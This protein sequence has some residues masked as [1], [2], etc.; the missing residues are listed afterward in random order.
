MPSLRNVLSTPDITA[1]NLLKILWTTFVTRQFY[2]T[3]KNNYKI[4]NFLPAEQGQL[5]QAGLVFS[6]REVILEALQKQTGVKCRLQCIS[7]Y[8]HYQVLTIVIQENH[9]KILNSG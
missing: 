9:S 2:L 6:Y 7:C 3:K 1:F 8:F 4:Y 5:N